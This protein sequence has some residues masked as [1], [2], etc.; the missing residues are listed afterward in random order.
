MSVT[1]SRS[2]PGW[3]SRSRSPE[4]RRRTRTYAELGVSTDG[5]QLSEF[6]FSFHSGKC[7]DGKP[8][9]S[10]GGAKIDAA[11]PIGSTGDASYSRLFEHAWEPDRA[12]KRIAGHERFTFSATFDGT[13]VSG[14]LRDS[15]KASK[16]R[17]TSGPIKFVAYR[18][19]TPQ[20]PLSTPQV[21]SATYTGST[22]NGADR[23]AAKTLVPWGLVTSAT[24]TFKAGCTG[25]GTVG[26]SLSL[27]SAPLQGD[28]F[29]IRGG[30]SSSFGHGFAGRTRYA[31]TG[32]FFS[33]G[34]YRVKL[35]WSYTATIYLAG[36]EVDRCSAAPTIYGTS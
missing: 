19:G 7:S 17:C 35:K 23:I 20:A 12:G 18:D 24:V 34:V 13:D 16:L 21:T 8:F 26:A 2:P 5:K 31:L 1:P 11:A 32:N 4:A 30:G 27:G 6:A 22:S 25:G 28:R 15:F 10:E 33:D 29:K 3:R 14:K 36:R 9:T